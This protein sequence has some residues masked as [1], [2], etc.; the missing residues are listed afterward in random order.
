MSTNSSIAVCLADGSV[1]SVYCHYDGFIHHNGRLLLEYWNSQ[2]LAESLV[3]LGNI[4][5]LG[6]RLKPIGKHA[7]NNP[8]KGTCLFYG[9][10]RKDIIGVNANV[11]K[12]LIDYFENCDFRDYNY[13][14]VN[15]NWLVSSELEFGDN[16]LRVLSVTYKGK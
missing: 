7:F 2:E 11:W 8:E 3:S 13:L 1:I 15:D 6:Q 10:D 9:R 5:V 16:D 12:S 4:S 14:F